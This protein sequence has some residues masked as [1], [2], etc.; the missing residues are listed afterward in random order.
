MPTEKGSRAVQF[1]FVDIW[2]AVADRVPDRTAIVCGDRRTTYAELDDAATRFAHFLQE[3]GVGP[4]DHVGMY[5]LNGHEYMAAFFGAMKISAVPINVNYRYVADELRYLFDDADLRAVVFHQQYLPRVEE[6]A[7]D[8]PGLTTFVVVDDGSGVQPNGALD[9][10]AWDDVLAGASPERDFAP[11][12]GDDRYVLYTGGTTGMPKG[13]VWRQEDAFFGCIGGG[14]PTR[15]EGE[16]SSPEELLDRI[17]EHPFS[18]LPVA[19]LMHAAAQWTTLMWLFVGGK[20]VLMPGSMDP[21]SVWDAVDAE[22]VNLITV[23]GDAVVRPLMDAWDEGGGADRWDVSSLFSV[24]SGGAPLS[25]SLKQRMARTFPNLVIADGFGSS[26]TGIQGSHRVTGKDITDGKAHFSSESNAVVVDDDLK[27]VEPGSG[28]IGRVGQKGRIPLEYYGDPEKTAATLVEVGGE[29][30]ILSGDMATVEADGSVTLL[31][32]GSVCIN[33][34]GEKVFPE[35]VEAVLKA[36]PAV[37][38][39]VVVGVPDDRWGERVAAVVQT[40]PGATLTPEEAEAHSREHLAG[41]KVPR[42]LTVVEQVV[43][44]PAGKADYRWAKTIATGS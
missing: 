36:H 11:R 19:P 32:R 37:Y 41:Y 22:K 14:D 4:G 43:R 5:L 44:S 42:E 34:G 40:V 29:R 28:V 15:L 7:G 18:F 31:G 12:S 38:D 13:V 21:T 39:A 10:R 25:A 17:G 20:V 16:V 9:A 3:R 8:V 24:G 35:E 2:E 30:V 33:T 6:V 27:L 23:V 26:E 1:N